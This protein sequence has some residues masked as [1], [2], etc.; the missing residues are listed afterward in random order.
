MGNDPPGGEKVVFFRA[1]VRPEPRALSSGPPETLF[2]G[3]SEKNIGWAKKISKKTLD[4]VFKISY[5]IFPRRGAA[6]FLEKVA[7]P[8]LKGSLPVLTGGFPT[9]GWS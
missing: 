4:M 8:N 2:A 7:R 9:E 1:E 5:I 3:G 6:T